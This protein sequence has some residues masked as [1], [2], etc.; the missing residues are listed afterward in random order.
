MA[1]LASYRESWDLAQRHGALLAGTRLSGPRASGPLFDLGEWDELLARSQQLRPVLEAQGASYTLAGMEPYRAAVLL[2]RGE[3]TAARALIE[4]VLPAAREIADLQ[5][6][7]PA[8]A[9]AALAEQASG[10]Q[11]GR[12][13]AG[14]RVRGGGAGQARAGRLVLGLVV[15]GRPRPHLRGGG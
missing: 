6:L 1:A 11:P 13:R 14:R 4:G 12:A 5:V 7:V 8:L 15:P 2:W 10:N 3:L 9:V